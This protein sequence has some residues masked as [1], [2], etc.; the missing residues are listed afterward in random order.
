MR[1]LERHLSQSYILYAT[2]PTI[3]LVYDMFDIG[4]VPLDQICHQDTTNA[5][6]NGDNLYRAVLHRVQNPIWNGIVAIAV[7]EPIAIFTTRFIIGNFVWA[8]VLEMWS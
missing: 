3:L 1:S 5:G 8:G 2:L 6:S 7:S 4:A